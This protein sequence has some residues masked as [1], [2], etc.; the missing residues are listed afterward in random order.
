MCGITGIVYKDTDRSIAK[1][2]LLNMAETIEHRGPDDMSIHID[3]HVGLGFKR[4]SIIDLKG[5][6]QP[7]ISRDGNLMMICNGEIYNYRELRAGLEAKG[8]VFRSDC[9]VEVILH[10]YREYGTDSVNKLNGQFAFALYDKNEQ[11]LFFSRD[12]FGICPFF[13]SHQDNFF[14]F[15]S[16]MKAILAYPELDR[17]IDLSGLDQ[18]FS[19]PAIIAPTTLF[20]QIRSLEPGY[21]GIYQKG[22]LKLKQYWDLEYPTPE[23]QVEQKS[24]SYYIERLN[25]LVLKSVKQ[26]LQADVPVGFYLSGGLDSSII[27][28]TMRHL[29][30]SGE[31]NSFSICFSGAADNKDINEQRFQRIMSR[32]VNSVHNEIEFDWNEF[33]KKLKDVVYFS[34]SPLKE[35]YNVCSLAL[36]QRA[37]EKNIKV[38]LSGE[39]ADELFGGYAGYKF[40]SQRA[41]K[42]V[43]KDLE[44]LMEDQVRKTIWGDPDFSY[45]KNEYEFKS[46]KE[47]L[48]SSQVNTV[49]PQFDCLKYPAVN[50]SRIKG[51]HVFHQRSYVDFKLRLAGHLI[52]DHG[53]RMTMANNV[54]GRYPFLDPDLVSFVREIPPQMMLKDMKEKYLLK[55]LAG[56]YIPQEI[57]S[58]EKFGFVAPGSPQLLKQGNEWVNDMLSYDYI[59]RRGYFNPDTIERLKKMYARKD[60]ILNPPYDMDLL[61]IVLTF[62]V[63]TSLFNVPNY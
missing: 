43:V 27:G 9:D 5:G 1:E 31:V 29:I 45:E 15:G 40:D 34:E 20:A 62:N 22:E 14:L 63:F 12:H 28:G 4:L 60:F 37:K 24:E 41:G 13:Y 53:D 16:E 17:R 19:Y 51:R 47:A 8:H 21:F 54:E 56:R 33:D 38:V 42:K 44:H 23:Q 61:I 39:G 36:S 48:Y 57:I 52:A 25:E 32:H 35:T 3:G 49:Y 11:S 59:K 10:L 58:R 2:T 55:Q 30:G 6:Q 18:I 50:H 46:T 26:R 7:F